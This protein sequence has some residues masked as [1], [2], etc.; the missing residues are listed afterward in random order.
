MFSLR[1]HGTAAFVICLLLALGAQGFSDTDAHA[2]FESPTL[3]TPGWMAPAAIATMPSPMD[4]AAIA[5]LP[6]LGR[7]MLNPRGRV[8]DWLGAAFRGR[9]LA[10]PINVVIVDRVSSSPEEAVKRLECALA[11]SS[12]RNRGGHSTGYSAIIGDVLYSQLHADRRMAFS[13]ADS[14]RLNDHGRV[15]GPAPCDFGYVFTAAFSREA[16]DA[17]RAT[18]VLVS[19][20]EAR[21]HLAQTLTRTGYYRIAA[22]VP[23]GNALPFA[24]DRTTYDHDGVAVLLVADP[25]A[26][27]FAPD[28]PEPVFPTIVPPGRRSAIAR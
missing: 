5:G 10:E 18:H 13:D 14:A 1:R 8:A 23:M 16:P 28:L 24:G 25:P 26:E 21:D 3:V 12:F 11:A 4:R 22:F 2:F 19:F 17:L 6:P 20:N 9:R 7:W 15:F 27:R